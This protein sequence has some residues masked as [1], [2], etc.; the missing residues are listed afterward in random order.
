TGA[1][2]LADGASGL[3][4]GVSQLDSGAGQLQDGTETYVSGVG[5]Y[6]QGVRSAA[7]GAD[8]LSDGLGQLASGAGDLSEGISTFESE[9][10]K[11]AEELPTYSEEDRQQLSTVVASPVAQADELTSPAKVASTSL[12][13]VAAL[14][15]GALGAFIVWRPVPRD[16]VTS[17]AASVLLWARTLWLPAAVVVGVGLVL[18][19]VGAAVLGLGLGASALLVLLMMLLGGS[20]ALANHALAGWLGNVGRAVS[21]LLLVVTVGLGLSS[22]LGWLSPIG[23]VSPLQNGLE[24]VRTHMADGTGEVGLASVALLLAV[25][26][27]LFSV[28]AISAKRRLTA[29]QFREAHAG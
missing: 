18:G 8:A 14:W 15:L 12:L 3:A 7:E 21:A 29:A 2:G 4:D 27:L 24:L 25:I 26:A 6:T 20:F 5:Q 22:T 19:V 11:G 10:S 28:T 17:R 1:R 13:I 23:A 9:L 16:V